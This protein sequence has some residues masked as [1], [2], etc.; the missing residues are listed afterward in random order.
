VRISVTDTGAGMDPTVQERIF[1]PFFT[2]RAMGRGTG[3]GLATAYGI[4]RNHGGRIQVFSEQ[5]KGTTFRVDLP[6][7]EK[8]ME[9]AMTPLKESHR[10]GS[11]TILLVD[12]EE[13]VRDVGQ[14]LL[15]KLGYRVLTAAGGREAL[16]V[17][18]ADPSQFDLV[19]LDMVMPDIGG[20]EVFEQ[21]R[22]KRSDTRVLLSSGYSQDGQASEILRK[23]CD[24][25]IQKPFDLKQLS[26]KVREVLDGP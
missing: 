22:A 12:D 18:S 25:F 11:E 19:V 13:M 21:L 1:E 26:I 7:S 23:G 10:G 24:G 3:L 20:K 15:E 16:E 5:G 8:S 2:T 6:A 4:V 14:Q 9:E 17:F